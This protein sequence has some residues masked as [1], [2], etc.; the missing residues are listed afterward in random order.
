MEVNVEWGFQFLEVFG[1]RNTVESVYRFLIGV[2]A[3]FNHLD[4]QDLVIA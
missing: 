2:N 1:S 4:H 3:I